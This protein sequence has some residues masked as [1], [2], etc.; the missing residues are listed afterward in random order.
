MLFLLFLI[1]ISF[2]LCI[3]CLPMAK[4]KFDK[5]LSDKEQEEFLRNY[6]NYK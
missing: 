2:T 6:N 4:T 5:Q 1:F 3:L